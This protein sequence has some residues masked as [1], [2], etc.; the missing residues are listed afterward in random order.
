MPVEWNGD[1][2]YYR[3]G[4]AAYHR[5]AEL[6]ANPAETIGDRDEWLRGYR[7]AKAGQRSASEGRPLKGVGKSI[8]ARHAG[9]SKVTTFGMSRGRGRMRA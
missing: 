8:G 7:E 3:A 9:R 1:H 4:I 2:N 5:G 6:W